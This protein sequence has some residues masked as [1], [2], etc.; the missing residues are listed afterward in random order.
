MP[1]ANAKDR[2]PPHQPAN[3]FM[4]VGQRRRIA[5]REE[6]NRILSLYHRKHLPQGA[7]TSPALANRIAYRLDCRLEGLS[8][9]TDIVYS[10]YAD[11]LLFS[12]GT[13]FAR[14]AV[15]FSIQVAAIALEEGFRVHHRK[16]RRMRKS[17]RQSAAGIVINRST[18]LLR[19]EFDQLKAILF[20]CVRH[21]P[22]TQNRDRHPHFREHLIGRINWINQLNP[23]RGAR[24]RM[25][26]DTIAWT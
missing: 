4:H 5:N 9:A 15:P 12:G 16:T 3:A 24:L 18:N 6:R 23:Q 7:P 20:N 10:R 13:A 8:V 11:D 25:V 2:R 26:F 21:G 1:E 17:T 14:Q 19:T 22:A